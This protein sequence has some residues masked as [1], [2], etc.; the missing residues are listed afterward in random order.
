MEKAKSIFD[1][2]K[3]FEIIKN[4]YSLIQFLLNNKEIITIIITILIV[5]MRILGFR[6]KTYKITNSTIDRLKREK[7]CS[8]PY[9]LDA[10]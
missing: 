4:I 1:T 10:L 7:K 9:Y 8:E 5:M 6:R 2:I 3:E